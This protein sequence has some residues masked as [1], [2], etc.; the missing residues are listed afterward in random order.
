MECFK[1]KSINPE[2][3]KYCGNCGT[4]LDPS[5]GA[6]KETL[7]P[8][9]QRQ[10]D[11]ALKEQVKDQKL[12]EIE[13]AQ[14]I[15]V[16]MQEWAKL[17]GYF[18]GIPLVL[19]AVLLGFLGIRTFS[20]FKARIDE[21]EKVIEQRVTTFEEAISQTLQTQQ[22][23]VMAQTSISQT[24]QQTQ[25]ETQQLSQEANQAR[26]EF[27]NLQDELQAINTLRDGVEILQQQVEQLGEAVN[28]RMIY[29][30]PGVFIMGSDEGNSDEQPMH[31]VYLDAFYIDGTE[32]TNAQYRACVE[33]GACHT[34]GQTT[35]YDNPDYAEH[36]VVYVSWNDANA[37]CWWAGRR[38]PTEA[39]WEKA[40]RG[41]DGRVYPWGN[42]FDGSKMNFC[43]RNCPYDWKDAS[44]DDGYADT[45]P[46]GS[47]LAGASPYGALDMA[48][49]VWEWV[50]DW[51]DSGY[52]S[53]LPQ[54]NPPGP[55]SSETR[56]LRGGSWKDGPDFVRC[57]SRSR[58]VPG[59]K[60]ESVGFRCAR[61]ALSEIYHLIRKGE[62]LSSIA[63]LYGVTAE[64]IVAANS[65]PS[66]YTIYAGQVLLI[67]IP[68]QS[69]G[70]S[71]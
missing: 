17:L 15:A 52:Y 43:D 21:G 58:L 18:V 55:D 32:V 31:T 11:I 45:A 44:V 23:I 26:A 22:E 48:G 28:I 5:L 66:P 25:Q 24:L 46:V 50:A 59:D 63:A 12:V 64:A 33:A 57:A 16:R 10:V 68:E 51:Y 35:Y 69:G 42:T 6:L 53:Q 67:P 8:I 54:R 20:D 47:Y 9:I 65:I 71:P 60:N 1:C 4:N 34:P 14:A 70:V 41:M 2:G 30:P 3:Q 36:P 62:T 37:Y 13:T 29:M 39:E 56:V 61:A 27:Q 19:L 49:N 40:A 38:L 7:E